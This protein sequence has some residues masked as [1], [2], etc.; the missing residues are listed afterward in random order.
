MAVLVK[1]SRNG[2]FVNLSTLDLSL[3]SGCELSVPADDLF[4]WLDNTYTPKG[5]S[6]CEGS[7]MLRLLHG[8]DGAVLARFTVIRYTGHGNTFTGFHQYADIPMTFF[9]DLFEEGEARFMAPD[10]SDAV[11]AAG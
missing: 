10:A 11:K 3:G 1:A 4:F 8:P 9:L 5:F 7:A 6:V 2:I